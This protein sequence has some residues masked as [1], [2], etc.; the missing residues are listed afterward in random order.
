MAED[1]LTHKEA[2]LEAAKVCLQKKGYART[3]VRDLVAESGSNLSSIGYH[4]GSKEAL[5]ATAFDDV[6]KQWTAQLNA[7]AMDTPAATA[8]ERVAASWKEMLDTLPSHAGLTL[9]FVESIGPSVRS[10]ELRAR[11][12]EHYERARRDVADVV[13]ES[14]G[15]E[16]IAAGADPDVVASYLVAVADGFMIQFLIDPA[17]C[18]TGDE[19]VQ[20]L[21]AALTAGL[22][23]IDRS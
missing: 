10:P 11:L 19:L 7:A 13:R 1:A 15:A 8:L 2:L 21:G 3:T 17:R 16:A 14:L 22:S 6:F 5:L 20:A 18:P 23:P 12:A 9:A 4:Y